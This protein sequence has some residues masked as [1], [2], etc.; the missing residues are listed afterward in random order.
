MH[1]RGLGDL[2][3]VGGSMRGQKPV[4]VT[5][6]RSSSVL[7]QALAKAQ[8]AQEG[9]APPDRPSV[10]PKAPM[11]Q[12]EMLWDVLHGAGQLVGNPVTDVYD[13]KT[14]FGQGNYGTSA[15]AALGTIPLVGEGTKAVKALR[16]VARA[17]GGAVEQKAASLIG[18][19]PNTTLGNIMN[20]MNKAREGGFSVGLGSGEIPTEGVV[21]GQ[22][23][24]TDA[25]VIHTGKLTKENVIDAVARNVK[26][27]ERDD[28]VL[29]SWLDRNTGQT[30]IEA[31]K[32][33]TGDDAARKATYSGSQTGQKAGWDI[34]GQREIPVGNW[35][36]NMSTDKFKKKVLEMAKEGGEYLSNQDQREWWN[37]YGSH[38][39]RVYGPEHLDKLAGFI[40]STAPNTAPTENLRKASEYMRRFIKGENIVQPNYVIPNTARTR[41]PGGQIGMET[42][43]VANLQK[44]S[45]G[46]LA[47]LQSNKVREEAAALIGD[48]NAFVADRWWARLFEDPEAG[49]FT[50]PQEGAVPSPER[51]ALMKAAIT[52]M[53]KEVGRDVR[54]FSADAWTGIR[55]RVKRTGELYG[56]KFKASAVRGDSK[57]YAD[58]FMDEI[59]LKAKHLGISV[60]E[61]ESRLRKGDAE[62]LG[63]MLTIPM[64]RAMYKDMTTAET[65][66]RKVNPNML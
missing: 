25:R 35:E 9:Y 14:A 61:L 32:V 37:L 58:I 60:T 62:L 49:I 54:D 40:A 48:P 18:N 17:L 21:M 16:P 7:E 22:Y 65:P 39:E 55:E 24:N 11:T 42:G 26:T 56:T 50:G 59:K 2:L 53:A 30:T 64:A 15:L 8:L 31:S 63:V 57:S 3:G 36:K 44:S 10:A 52:D 13:A 23:P 51:Y 34:A 38:F 66:D 28:N 5:A 47:N 4:V 29:G 19:Y 12:R 1:A 41:T 20:K 46:D 43:R 6:P 33:Y 45:Q 27:L